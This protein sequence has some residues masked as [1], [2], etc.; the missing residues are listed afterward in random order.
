MTDVVFM[1]G[2]RPVTAAEA[3]LALGAA[4]LLLLVALAI[5]L[6]RAGRKRAFEAGEQAMRAEE[7]ESRIAE[8]ARIQSES[9]GR[10]QTLTEVLGGRQA[11][12]ARVVSER[13]DTVSH[14]LGEGMSNAARATTESLRDRKSV[15]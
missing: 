3:L 6:W 11:D 15:V 9:S 4:A 12:L 5:G 1:L 14:R 10:M 8:L 2:T 7:L 13:L